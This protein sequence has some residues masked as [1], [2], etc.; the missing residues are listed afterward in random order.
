MDYNVTAVGIS[1][2]GLDQIKSICPRI[3]THCA[4]IYTFDISSYDY[5]LTDSMLHFYKN[6]IVKE[7]A[8]VNSII[9][10]MKPSAV[11]INCMILSH[12]KTFLNILS[13]YENIEIIQNT[14]FLYQNQTKY[15]MTVISK[16]SM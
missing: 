7:T 2:V 1:S 3:K 9:S 13:N 14:N 6:D 8:L 15:N 4:D 11:Y 10:N 12:H 16:A 5:I